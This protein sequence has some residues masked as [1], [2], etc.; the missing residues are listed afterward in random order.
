MNLM[1]VRGGGALLM[2]PTQLANP[3]RIRGTAGYV[4]DL[5][6]P[7]ERELCKGQIHKLEPAPEGSKPARI[8][9][10][11]ALRLIRDEEKRLAVPQP[12]PSEPATAPTAHAD[13]DLEVRRGVR[14]T[15]AVGA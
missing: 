9:H 12:A 11:G 5:D 10:P 7:L 6:A 8:V 15:K 2:W 3:D 1:Q 13:E 14:K 4:V